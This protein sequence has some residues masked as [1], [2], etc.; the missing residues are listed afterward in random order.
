LPLAATSLVRRAPFGATATSCWRAP[1]K[2][3]SRLVRQSAD[4]SGTRVHF[5]I[6]PARAPYPQISTAC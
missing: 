3:V 6:D 4:G 5:N 2:T 1:D